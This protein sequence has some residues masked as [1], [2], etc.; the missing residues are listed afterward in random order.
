MASVV[1]TTAG[2]WKAYVRRTGFPPQMKT[3][4]LKRDAE[5]WARRVEDEILRGVYIAR[6]GAEKT[7]LKQAL[8]RYLDEVSPTKKTGAK[9]EASCANALA[10]AL[11]AYRLVAITP[12]IVADYRDKRLESRIV[13]L[14]DTKNRSAR[15]VPLTKR[16]TEALR[17]AMAIPVLRPDGC[18]LIFFGETG[19]PICSE[20]A[21]QTARDAAGLQG[22]HFHDLRHEAVSR[23]VE[24][25]WAIRRCQQSAAIVL[26][27]CSSATR[28]FARRIWRR[29]SIVWRNGDWIASPWGTSQGCFNSGRPFDIA[30]LSPRVST[31][32]ALDL[33]INSSFPENRS[34]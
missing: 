27:R 5:D 14:A 1:R 8:Q 11:G 22:L 33:T 18:D 31:G 21:W 13:F 4:R 10:V 19:R 26:C 29:N 28:T 16:A 20:E 30:V 2:T 34:R 12:D 17:T 3:F 6:A 15:A 32:A 24:E 9:R 25:G 7:K 23:L